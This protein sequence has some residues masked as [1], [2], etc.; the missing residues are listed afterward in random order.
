MTKPTTGPSPTPVQLAPDG[1]PRRCPLL[2]HSGPTWE[3]TAP[4][5][6]TGA[7]SAITAAQTVDSDTI[8]G[9]GPTAAE[10]TAAAAAAA[11]AI[12]SAAAHTAENTVADTN[13]A[14]ADVDH[15]ASL[16]DEQDKGN[17]SSEVSTV[18]CQFCQSK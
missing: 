3:G 8:G 2:R 16:G 4:S 15:V 5:D 7:A 6:S 11:A 17:E 12:S 18:C 10:N 1:M 13:A 9:S 14:V